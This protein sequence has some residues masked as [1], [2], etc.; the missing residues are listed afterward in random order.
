MPRWKPLPEGTEPSVRQLV[1][2]LRRLKDR[3][4]LTLAAL[5]A[6]TGCSRSS[7]ERYL[8]GRALPSQRAVRALC[9][10]TGT[11]PVRLLALR[12][13]A[14]SVWPASAPDD[15]NNTA[16][17]GRTPHADEEEAGDEDEAGGDDEAGGGPATGGRRT[18]RRGVGRG[19]FAL[20]VTAAFAAAALSGA[21]L[22][23]AA[24]HG[25]TSAPRLPLVRCQV[26]SEEG[27]L[28]AGYSRTWR[29]T[30]GL[31]Y[32]REEVAEAECLLSRHGYDTGRVDG[33]Y[34]IATRDAVRRAQE[35]A[36]EVNDG[37][38]GQDTWPVLRREG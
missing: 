10:L 36:G 14:Q 8:G 5:E 35:H 18:Q 23:R 15:G 2:H 12:E 30:I 19:M 26:H 27:A 17:D 33:L 7:W 1:S 16:C 24:G 6:K 21:L 38:V 4:G 37:I 3:S 29:K 31:G 11:D 34:D 32:Y 13:V 9:E 28:Y 20:V 22:G 25:T